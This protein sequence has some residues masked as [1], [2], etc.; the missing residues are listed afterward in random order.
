MTVLDVGCAMGYFSIPLAR[1]VGQTGKVICVDMQEKMLQALEKRAQKA[2]VADR[3]ALCLCRQETLRLEA[4]AEKIDFALVFAVVHEVP[5][6][7]KLFAQLAT[8]I[9]PSGTV[10]VAEP[11]GHVSEADFAKTVAAAE[12]HGLKVVETPQVPRSRA[13]LLKKQKQ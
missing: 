7:S 3:I 13:V 10:L 6:S 12:Q 2:G 5:D 9:A 4:M 1:M 11:K 8:A